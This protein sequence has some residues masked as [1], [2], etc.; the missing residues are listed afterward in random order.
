MNEVKFLGSA[1]GEVIPGRP[2]LIGCPLDATSTYRMG[3]AAASAAIRIASDSLE[4]YSPLLDSDLSDVPFADMGDL[5]LVRQPLD[6]AL[7]KIGAAVAQALEKDAKPVCIGGEH[8]I[9]LPAIASLRQ[10]NDDFVVLHLDAHSD[11]RDEYDGNP[12]SHA[13]VIK[14]VVELVGPQRL[15]QLGVRAGTREE[16][17]WMRSNGTLR[18]W[19]GRTDKMLLDSI[20]RRPVYLTI[21]LDVLDP[22]CFPGTGNPEPGGWFYADMER[23]LCLV[24]RMKVLAADVVELNPGLD[25]SES[26]TITAAKIIRELLLILG[27]MP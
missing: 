25:P 2:V 3:S 13:T 9:T 17:V 11:L 10:T 8:T 6:A 12:I 21:D 26:S 1:S 18:T 4:T 16:F 15:I 22:A 24:Q 5:P 23:F 19:N 7:Q 14:R 20:G 27:A